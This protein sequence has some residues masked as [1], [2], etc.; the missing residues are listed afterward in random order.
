MVRALGLRA[1]NVVVVLSASTEH[2]H[3]EQRRIVP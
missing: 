2:Q 3:E 1:A